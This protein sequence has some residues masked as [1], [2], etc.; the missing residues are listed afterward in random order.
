VF[1]SSSMEQIAAFEAI[2]ANNYRPV[3]LLGDRQIN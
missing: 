1:S 2:F 3:Q